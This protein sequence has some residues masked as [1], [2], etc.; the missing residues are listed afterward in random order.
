MES[1]SLFCRKGS[2]MLV[3]Y[4]VDMG[5]DIQLHIYDEKN[6]LHVGALH[7][8]LNLCKILIE[9]HSFYGDVA[10][11]NGWEAFH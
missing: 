6:G 10:D 7:G 5:T 3:A 8:H 4:F 2:Y 1:I 9:K 11:S